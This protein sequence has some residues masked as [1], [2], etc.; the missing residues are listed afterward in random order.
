MST[1]ETEQPTVERLSPSTKRR[2]ARPV[3]D[4][5]TTL[6]GIGRQLRAVA[7]RPYR[8]DAGVNDVIDLP[9]LEEFAALAVTADLALR[10]AVS[11][12]RDLGHSW[13]DI[14]NALGITRQS[15][16]ERFGR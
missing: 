2:S 3:D 9:A 7:K 14:G 16:H 15:A 10:A 5:T 13:A 1:T 8:A 11:H 12:L 6:V 4:V